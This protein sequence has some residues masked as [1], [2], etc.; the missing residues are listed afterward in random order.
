VSRHESSAWFCLTDG[1][2]TSLQTRRC[3]AH[4]RA[5][6]HDFDTSLDSWQKNSSKRYVDLASIISIIII[7]L[8]VEWSLLRVE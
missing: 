2:F 4:G 1:L 3:L 5:G 7:F 8:M 6:H